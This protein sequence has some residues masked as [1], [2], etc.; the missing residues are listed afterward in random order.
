MRVWPEALRVPFVLGTRS[1]F[2]PR[3]IPTVASSPWAH[4]WAGKL[5]VLD[6][7]ASLMVPPCKI[8][9]RRL[10]QELCN[11][12]CIR[13]PLTNPKTTRAMSPLLVASPL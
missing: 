12:C 5:A 2:V 3:A 13:P 6:P 1:H 9:R 11:Y 7:V 8:R 4:E 10:H